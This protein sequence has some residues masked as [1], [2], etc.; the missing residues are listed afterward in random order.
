[1]LKTLLFL[2]M[3]S[4]NPCC[5]QSQ[6]SLTES[7]AEKKGIYFTWKEFYTSTPSLKV[8]FSMEPHSYLIKSYL[9]SFRYTYY[10]KFTDTAVHLDKVFSVFDGS[11]LYL[12]MVMINDTFLFSR[13]KYAGKYPF[14]VYNSRISVSGGS[15][16]QLG[17][18]ALDAL[19]A[20]PKPALYF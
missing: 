15:L 10:S 11:N 13:M 2:S 8:P 3:L 17:V 16:L 14:V 1:M 6:D 4:L 7:M 5:I 19:V 18:S 9:D 12:K 20:S